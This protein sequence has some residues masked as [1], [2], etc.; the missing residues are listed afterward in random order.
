MQL[1]HSTSRRPHLRHI[2][3]QDKLLGRLRGGA[4]HQRCLLRTEGRF[5]SQDMHATVQLSIAGVILKTTRLRHICGRVRL[6]TRLLVAPSCLYSSSFHSR[7]RFGSSN[8]STRGVKASA[9]S[10]RYWL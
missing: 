9:V 6:M 10:R 1:P 4:C 7:L 2:L 5:S 3:Q 8:G